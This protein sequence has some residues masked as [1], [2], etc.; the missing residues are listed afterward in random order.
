MNS[1]GIGPKHDPPQS[2][3]ANHNFH[4]PI[5]KRRR[6]RNPEKLALPIRSHFMNKSVLLLRLIYARFETFWQD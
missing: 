2:K 5:V 1:D 6:S 4:H 3:V